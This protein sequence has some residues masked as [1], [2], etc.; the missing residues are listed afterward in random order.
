MASADPRERHLAAEI[1]SHSRWG[2]GAPGAA[3]H[4]ERV[5][6]ARLTLR[7]ARARR[8]AAELLH[9]A[10]SAEAELAAGGGDEVA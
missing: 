3:E 6:V 9:I 1:A 4:Q 5:R 8:K 7:S 10:A 2:P